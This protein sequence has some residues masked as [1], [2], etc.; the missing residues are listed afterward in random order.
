M[1]ARFDIW[2]GGR[3][4]DYGRRNPTGHIATSKAANELGLQADD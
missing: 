3:I 1:A 2:I 4:Y